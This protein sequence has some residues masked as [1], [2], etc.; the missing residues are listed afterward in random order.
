[1]KAPIPTQRE[2]ESGLHQRYH[3][4][5]IVKDDAGFFGDDQ[6]KLVPVDEGAEY[7][8]MRLDEGGSD[9]K[10]IAACRLGIH[11]YADA[12]K[13]HLPQLSTDLKSRYPL[14]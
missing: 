9:L 2:N 8:I 12:I 10:H 1:M 4:Q 6:Y 14:L 11:A 7:F 13:D 5:K 3:I